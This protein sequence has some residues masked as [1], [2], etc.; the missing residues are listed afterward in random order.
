MQ[1]GLPHH[2]G[3][4]LTRDASRPATLASTAFASHPFAWG[5]AGM[6]S[7]GLAGPVGLI[8]CAAAPSRTQASADAAIEPVSAEL[9]PPP[10]RRVPEK[11]VFSDEPDPAFAEP[12]TDAQSLAQGMPGT[13][14][15]DG[16]APSASSSDPQSGLV[17]ALAG[18]YDDDMKALA[19]MQADRNRVGA[20]APAFN[21]APV[22]TKLP[23]AK[24]GAAD[25]AG[26]APNTEV[27]VSTPPSSARTPAEE[28]KTA[29]AATTAPAP[30]NAPDTPPTTAAPSDT[31]AANPSES[32]SVPPSVP[33]S[34]P[35]SVA[36]AVPSKDSLANASLEL[37]PA[38]AAAPTDPAELTRLLAE[39]LAKRGA[40][41]TEPTRDWLAYAA[42][43]IGEP[44]LSLPTDF[45]SDLLPAE[46]ERIEKV[47]TA[48]AAV[49][50][51]LAQGGEIDQATAEGL[52]AALTGGPKL[53]I[54]KVEFCKK[55][56]SFGRFA[57]LGSDR[58]LARSNARFILYTELAGFSS[59][60]VDGEFVTRLATRVSIESERDGIEVWARQPAWTAVVDHS[61][62]RRED[63]F[64]GEIVSVS[65]YLSVGS[66]RLK[67]EIRD[68]ASGR[69]A[70]ASHPLHIV[71]DPSMAAVGD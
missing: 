36:P 23:P 9:P 63:F 17:E 59:E 16:G 29:S 27:A 33:P 51:L 6:L 55:V 60:L 46:R 44:S 2:L 57:P 26:A 24:A 22:E 11:V 21:D 14:S 52:V 58:F 4:E 41:S 30:A 69:V 18:S 50:R 66:Y 53:E 47:H 20:A 38:P 7:L 71:A 35:T 56:E 31:T 67:I 28:P 49:G 42:L 13:G 34:V 70:T 48:F 3:H 5:V 10:T 64:V 54:P 32:T 65:E 37:P 43:A 25:A 19:A 45:G 40:S 39:S 15:S 62:T 8:G 68:E 1:Q 61:P 12:P